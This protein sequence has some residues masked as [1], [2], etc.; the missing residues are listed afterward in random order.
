MKKITFNTNNIKYT[1]E[2]GVTNN[3]TTFFKR[4]SF[5]YLINEKESGEVILE[6]CYQKHPKE[7]GI[8]ASRLTFDFD[9][10]NKTKDFEDIKSLISQELKENSEIDKIYNVLKSI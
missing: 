9:I 7:E 4:A 2:I 10:E 8:L 3:K 1:T 6:F 5:D